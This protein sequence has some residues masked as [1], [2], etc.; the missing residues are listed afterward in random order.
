MTHYR[1]CIIGCV[2]TAG[3]YDQHLNSKNILTH[4]LAYKRSS[5]INLIAASDHKPELAK[6]FAQHWQIDNHYDDATIMLKMTRPDIVSICTPDQTHEDYLRL[7]LTIPDIKAVWCEKPLTTSSESS[8]ELIEL[9]KKRNIAL[10]VNYQRPFSDEYQQLR[11]DLKSNIHGSITKVL[12][13]YS[14]GIKHNGTHAIDL[15]LDWFNS[16]TVEK[17]MGVMFDFEKNDPTVDALIMFDETPVYFIGHNENNYSLFEITIYT[18][19][20]RLSLIESGQK[21]KVDIKQQ[22][23]RKNHYRYLTESQTVNMNLDSVLSKCLD[24]L[25]DKIENSDQTLNASRAQQALSIAEELASIA[26]NE[27][28]NPS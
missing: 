16:A 28:D 4:A 2:K 19:N 3:G 7:C 13:N 12:V 11:S 5:N 10:L 8:L 17:V 21:M 24:R 23:S 25:T 27:I 26:I 18:D 14:K 20:A 15:L 22:A 9:Y 6:K 1:A